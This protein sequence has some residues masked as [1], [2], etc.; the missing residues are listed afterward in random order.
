MTAENFYGVKV[1]GNGEVYSPENV[2]IRIVARKKTFEFF[3]CRLVIDE[4]VVADFVCR[5]LLE[6][7][8]CGELVDVGCEVNHA[9]TS[10]GALCGLAVIE[11]GRDNE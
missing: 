1:G 9:C 7:G 8:S 11:A 4:V 3:G 6:Y 5:I 2:N 10:C